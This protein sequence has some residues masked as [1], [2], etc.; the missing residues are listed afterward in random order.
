[1]KIQGFYFKLT[2]MK[3]V[4]F[5]FLFVLVGCQSS[6]QIVEKDEGFDVGA[7]ISELIESGDIDRK[8]PIVNRLKTIE[9]YTLE[10]YDDSLLVP[11]PTPF[12]IN[13][14]EIIELGAT[15]FFPRDSI[16]RAF[17]RDQ[18]IF[19]NENRSQF[20]LRKGNLKLRKFERA[21]PGHC[22]IFYKPIFN[23]DSSAMFLQ[24]DRYYGY[25][26]EGGI[27]F[28]VKENDKWVV[29]KFIPTWMN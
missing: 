24:H 13:E 8:V 25:F 20:S 3:L 27:H 26:G 19:L 6:S 1:M 16:S 10:Y 9:Y 21:F 11:P 22:Y 29:E 23:Q 28:L 5:C 15:D 17:V 7:I 4:N 2:K 18:L 14:M 12:A